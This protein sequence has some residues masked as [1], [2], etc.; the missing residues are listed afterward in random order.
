[1]ND[2]KEF[3]AVFDQTKM[4]EAKRKIEH[5]I[6]EEVK[7]ASDSKKGNALDNSPADTHKGL[8][9]R[10]RRG[11]TLKTY[12]SEHESR[13]STA[14]V[15]PHPPLKFTFPR[16]FYQTFSEKNFFA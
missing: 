1:M 6:V 10:E 16:W 5:E 3:K 15:L 8:T 11:Q 12:P 14:R 4:V 7:R 2:L 9:K 13:Y